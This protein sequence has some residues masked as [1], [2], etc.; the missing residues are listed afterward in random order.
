[1][2]KI[3]QRITG[4]SAKELFDADFRSTNTVKDVCYPLGVEVRQ[5]VRVY[6]GMIIGPGDLNEER[7]KLIKNTPPSLRPSK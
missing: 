5:S 3:A 6:A 7:K 1:M 2:S 4:L